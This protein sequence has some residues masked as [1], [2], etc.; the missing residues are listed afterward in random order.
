M[1]QRLDYGRTGLEVDLPDD[2]VVVESRGAPPLGDPEGAVHAALA[3]PIGAAPLAGIARG[4]RSA[5]VVISDR[6]RPVPNEIILRPVLETLERAGI[7]R[8]EIEIIVG[9]GLHRP[10]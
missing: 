2:A 5:A 9:T 10:N 4:R 1:R 3:R 8:G 7:P 6:T